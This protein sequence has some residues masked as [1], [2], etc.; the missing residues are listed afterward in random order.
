V[1]AV[2]MER[3]TGLLG[4]LLIGYVAAII[5]YMRE[6]DVLS[7]LLV[8]V[9]TVSVVVGVI[10]LLIMAK[11]RLTQKLTESKWCPNSIKTLIRYAG[12]Y[13]THPWL[14][15]VAIVISF[16]FQAHTILFH[17]V[18]LAA[19]GLRCD[20]AQLAVAVAGA[21]VIGLLP[22]SLGGLGL[23]DGSFIYVIGLYGVEYEVALSAMLLIRVLVVPLSLCGAYFY[24]T[25]APAARR[26]IRQR[27][28][29]AVNQGA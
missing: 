19:L 12:D 7:R 16:V 4:L 26:A 22:I 18:M 10:A 13:R 17:W 24:F 3:L 8:V 25:E 2:F 14:A 15:T 27:D 21:T 5:Q 1:L 20:P 9:G 6:G 11:F 29:T 28:D 23:V